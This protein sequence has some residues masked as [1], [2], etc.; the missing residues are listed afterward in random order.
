MRGKRQEDKKFV[1][2]AVDLTCIWT[3]SR[4]IVHSFTSIWGKRQ[5]DKKFAIEAVDLTCTWTFHSFTS[6]WVFLIIGV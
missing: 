4:S 2:E 5:E 1:I 3:S 6:N